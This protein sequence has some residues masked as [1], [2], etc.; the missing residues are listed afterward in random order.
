VDDVLDALE[1][2]E[3]LWVEVAVGVGYDADF[4]SN[5]NSAVGHVT[6]ARSH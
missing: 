6:V 5:A 3:N 2:R 4:H 1:E